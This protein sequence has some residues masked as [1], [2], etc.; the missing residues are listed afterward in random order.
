MLWYGLCGLLSRCV[1][2][3]RVHVILSGGIQNER[4]C[5]SEYQKIL[6]RLRRVRM[7]HYFPILSWITFSISMGV[8]SAL[9][10]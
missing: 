7:T 5:I 3:K 1:F 2:D 9:T 4:I 6:P 10:R 8:I